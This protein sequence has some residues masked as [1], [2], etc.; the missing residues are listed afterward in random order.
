MPEHSWKSRLRNFWIFFRLFDIQMISCRDWWPWTKPGYITMTRRQSNNQLS[1]GIAVHPL[2]P[3]K[4]RMQNSTRKVLACLVLLLS[5]RYPPHWLP[6]KWPN[7]QRGVLRISAGTIEGHF[8]G[9]TPR[10]AKF[11][12]EAL[13]LHDNIPAHWALATQ[14]NWPARASS[15]L[16]PHPILRIWL[17][18]TATCSLD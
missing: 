8:E 4:F 3:K 2:R 15:V 14:K 13:F 11:T 5:R 6:S 16:I 12:K 17:R 7:Y 1:G 10:R 18:P 9:K